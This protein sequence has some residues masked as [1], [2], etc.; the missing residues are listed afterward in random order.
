[1]HQ[2]EFFRE[3]C[4]RADTINKLAEKAIKIQQS[5]ITAK[6][7]KNLAIIL[8]DI[9][10]KS[11]AFGQLMIWSIIIF[12]DVLNLGERSLYLAEPKTHTEI[13][14]PDQSIEFLKRLT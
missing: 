9:Q 5:P 10:K 3:I 14:N 7:T 4:R 8:S 11:E 12:E 2:I 1:M 6:S 13:N